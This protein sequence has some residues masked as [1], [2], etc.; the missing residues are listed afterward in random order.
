MSSQV[1]IE[2]LTFYFTVCSGF[3]SCDMHGGAGETT[4]PS[5]DPWFCVRPALSKWCTDLDDESY[6]VAIQAHLAM[7]TPPPPT[8]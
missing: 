8:P 1:K 4:M 5:E 3:D 7:P 2:L 6:V